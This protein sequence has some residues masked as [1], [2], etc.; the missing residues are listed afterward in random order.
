MGPD[1]E[2]AMLLEA[3]PFRPLQM[4]PTDWTPDQA[5]VTLNARMDARLVPSSA[6]PDGINTVH[7]M[8]DPYGAMRAFT[9]IPVSIGRPLWTRFCVAEIWH[10]HEACKISNA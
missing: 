1:A 8:S 2:R 9:V 4:H 7:T 10:R 6:S 5:L 3:F